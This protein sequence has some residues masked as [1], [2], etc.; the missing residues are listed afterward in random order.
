M[1][2]QIEK[3]I[4]KKELGG[5]IKGIIDNVTELVNVIKNRII[6]FNQLN[7]LSLATLNDFPY[8]CIY[9]R[10]QGRD[11]I[12][13]E[14]LD[15]EN[16]YKNSLD[17]QSAI[18]GSDFYRLYIAWTIDNNMPTVEEGD[19]YDEVRKSQKF[20][21]DARKAFINFIYIDES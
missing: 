21:F 8:Y 9:S 12:V 4:R 16:N 11:N 2:N 5:E 15:D 20:I 10:Y 1:K 3:D 19:F 14:F 17:N 7:D 6:E 13:K 18:R